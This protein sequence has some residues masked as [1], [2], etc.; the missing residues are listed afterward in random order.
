MKGVVLA[1]GKGTRLYPMTKYVHKVL[2]PIYNRPM[3]DHALSV[4]YGLGISETVIV[5]GKEHSGQ[6]IDYLGNGS[7]H[8]M[9]IS[10]AVQEKPKGTADAL[11][12]AKPFVGYDDFA[13]I[14]ADNYFSELP[15]TRDFIS[16][17]M[18][19]VKKVKDASGYGVI[20]TGLLGEPVGIIEKPQ[21]GESDLALTGFFLFGASV[22]QRLQ[23]VQESVRK[24]LELT[25]V[26]KDYLHSD[27]L[28]LRYVTGEWVDA[29]TPE[30]LYV[31]SELARRKVR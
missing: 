2:L 11:L 6:I 26:L 1:A 24:E 30:N 28:R 4:L 14:M 12:A 3:I 18:V 19:Y 25:D 7:I 15:D 5:I 17:A 13:L 29:G 21:K 31:A 23:G 16:G 22:W 9:S 20:L 27:L 10:Y 8:G